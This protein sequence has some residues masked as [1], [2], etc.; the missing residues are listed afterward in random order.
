MF[1]FRLIMGLQSVRRI[2]VINTTFWILIVLMV[3]MYYQSA[4]I[5]C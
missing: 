5:V 2:R 4:L 3:R 1:V